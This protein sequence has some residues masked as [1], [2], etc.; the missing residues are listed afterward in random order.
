MGKRLVVL[1]L[2]LLLIASPAFAAGNYSGQN[3]IMVGGSMG[4]AGTTPPTEVVKVRYGYASN[5]TNTGLSS[6]DAVVWDS[7]SADG[8]T[9]SACT[10]SNDQKFAGILVTDIGT[11]DSTAV[12]GGGNN[13]G[14]I[15]QK[16]YVLLKVDTGATAGYRLVTSASTKLNTYGACTTQDRVDAAGVGQG[17]ISNDIGVLLATPNANGI[18]R[19]MLHD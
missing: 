10:A 11:A 9:I 3:V 7:T 12:R 4:P 1:I 17:P 5:N 6:G 19:A 15:A 13:I 18:G 2:G 8:Y 16:G 14:Y